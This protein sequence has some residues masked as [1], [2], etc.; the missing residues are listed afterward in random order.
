[1]YKASEETTQ[2]YWT[3]VYDLVQ[4]LS[5]F[6]YNHHMKSQSYNGIQ[7]HD[8][9]FLCFWVELNHYSVLFIVSFSAS[10]ADELFLV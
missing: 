5:P 2:R 1:M 6:C 8:H 3:Y 4:A 9:R 10:P 7:L